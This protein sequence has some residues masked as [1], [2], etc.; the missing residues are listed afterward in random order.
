[1]ARTFLTPIDLS[2]L[3]LTNFKVQNLTDNPIPYGAGHVY[4]NSTHNELRVYTGTSWIPVSESIEY[5][6]IA[7]RPAYGNP[8]RAYATTDT[9]VLYL[10]GGTEW[11][12]IG[13]GVDTTDTLTNKTIDN[14]K[15]TGNLGVYDGATERAEISLDGVNLKVTTGSG[16]IEL[17]PDTDVVS[18]GTGYGE[19]HLQKTEYWR[20][21]TLQGVIAAQSDGSL[22]LTGV[23]DGLQ[24]ESNVGDVK[25]NPYST[26]TWFNNNLQINGD[27]GIITTDVNSLHLT[28][29]NGTVT[30]DT[31]EFHTTKIELWKDGD[32]SGSRRGIIV[33]HPSDGS[34]SIAA[35]NQLVLESHSGDIDIVPEGMVKVYGTDGV[36]FRDT[37][38][39]NTEY[40]TIYRS[41]VGTARITAAD[42][43]ALRAVNDVIIYPGNDVGGHTGKAY[44]H[45]GDDAANA[46][47]EREIATIGTSQTLTNK[48]LGAYTVLGADLDA[49]NSYTVVNLVD[50]TSPQDAATKAYVDAT[51]Q[52]LSVLGSVRAASAS[53]VAD[54]TSVT[55]VG[56]V[57]VVN[58]DRVLLKN[59][60]TATENG[61]YIYVDRPGTS[62]TLVPSTVPADTD[63]KEGSYVL[64]EEGTYATQG[65]IVTA[66][67]AGAS[68]WTQ[69]SAAGQYSAGNG[70]DIT[71]SAISIK[72]NGSTTGF[73]LGSSGI[74][75]AL[76]GSTLGVSGD[77][78][79][80]NYGD[81][82]TTSMSGALV[83]DKTKVVY[84]YADTITGDS[85][86]GGVTG[87]TAFPVTHNLD[88]EDVVVSVYDVA[89]KSQ[90]Y[91]DVT[92]TSVNVVTIG[93]GAAPVTTASYRVVVHA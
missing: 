11:L 40:L 19:L 6:V 76:D 65:W 74:K 62:T 61:I 75:V 51:A 50:P 90:V 20:D 5:G 18:I 82:L 29:D 46:H 21:G 27:G 70:I 17:Q 83:V 25:I 92:V 3:E 86:D 23:N 85:T 58:G 47:P 22:R 1:M 31:S 2:G 87:T 44:I 14:G 4:Y 63:I 59:Q 55:T 33:A 80:V 24:L 30:T 37:T 71:D 84:K 35:S 7:D 41:G 38:G 66:F 72:L 89:T 93:F 68:T 43:L 73:D 16:D 36:S 42:D 8:G 69:F 67:S 79:Y 78:L 54:L 53:N 13:V 15:I 45:W 57:M 28:A 52:G 48:T 9:K 56:G 32:T 77:G 10:D 26:I 60:A 88:T 64:V 34:L 91:T 49:D 12:Q 39:S 81:G